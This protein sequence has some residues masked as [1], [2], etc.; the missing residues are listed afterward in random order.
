MCLLNK[1]KNSLNCANK[2]SNHRIKREGDYELEYIP[3]VRKRGTLNIKSP[4]KSNKIS[5]NDFSTNSKNSKLYQSLPIGSNN[6]RTF[7]PFY[8]ESTIQL[9]NKLWLPKLIDYPDLGRKSI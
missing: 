9:F 1:H 3:V 2:I 5:K 7:S 8:N 6:D 4:Q